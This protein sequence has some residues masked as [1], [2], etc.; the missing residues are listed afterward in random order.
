MLEAE[1]VL[2][3]IR[4]RDYQSAKYGTGILSEAITSES[5]IEWDSSDT[6]Y[7]ADEYKEKKVTL[8]HI[9]IKNIPI[10][11]VWFDENARNVEQ[12]MD[13]IYEEDMSIEAFRLR[14]LDEDDNE[15]KGFKYIKSVGTNEKENT[16]MDYDNQTS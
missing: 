3:E 15:I 12:C 4:L 13:C 10:R 16:P 9:G 2:G 8:R 5:R 14:F 7:Y 6:E 11:K 1:N